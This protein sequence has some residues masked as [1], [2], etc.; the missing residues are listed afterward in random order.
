MKRFLLA[1]AMLALA[2][3]AQEKDNGGAAAGTMFNLYDG[4]AP[5]SEICLFPENTLDDG[6][7]RYIYNVSSPTLEMF[8]PEDPDGS[9]VV[10]LPGG[11]FC[12]LS[13][14]HEGTMVARKLA[15]CGITAFVLKYRTTPV[16]LDEEQ[17]S[18]ATGVLQQAME[19]ITKPTD[20]GALW[21]AINALT[22]S[23]TL[24]AEAELGPVHGTYQGAVRKVGASLAYSDADRAVAFVRENAA[25]FGVDPDRIGIMGFSAGAITT[26]HQI[27]YH[28]AGS[29]PDFAGV[30]YGGWDETF[31][32]PD[33]PMP[34][35]MCSPTHDVFGVEESL[36]V[37]MALREAGG[38]VEHHFF[39]K[40]QH[41]DGITT[42]GASVDYWSDLFLAFLK[43]YGCIAGWK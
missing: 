6:E 42:T 7:N 30:I 24:A 5:G 18:A 19:V 37:F 33:D 32:A 3:C 21:Q 41:G 40:C 31:K 38:P 29:R 4:A 27:Q 34:V 23:S 36:N 13:Y 22:A 20:I 17:P 14:D 11:G 8:A 28:S 9:A 35:F 15:S 16:G 43:D 39:S 10:I 12:L 26:L 2:A 25:S 1:A